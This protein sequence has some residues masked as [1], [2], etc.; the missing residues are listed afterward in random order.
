S[1]LWK[2]WRPASLSRWATRMARRPRPRRAARPA[3]GSR[4]V[5]GAPHAERAGD[6]GRLGRA[7]G[8]HLDPGAEQ[9]AVRPVKRGA[10]PARGVAG[11][12]VELE[13][14]RADVDLLVAAHD[15]RVGAGRAA[16]R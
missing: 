7:I 15:V 16:P 6:L 9:R 13:D 8:R 2:L 1:A 14:A 11:D 12:H 10:Q 4:A 5:I 3:R